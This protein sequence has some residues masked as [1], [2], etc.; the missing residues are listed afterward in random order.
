MRNAAVENDLQWLI[1]QDNDYTTWRS[2]NNRYWP[3]KYMV[4]PN[5]NL[6]F[7]HFGEGQY[8]ETEQAIRLLLTE[9]GN[10]ISDIDP[11]FKLN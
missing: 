9:A 11:T 7:R 1:V 2:F 3:A 10:D 6:R 4:D 5:G 8:A